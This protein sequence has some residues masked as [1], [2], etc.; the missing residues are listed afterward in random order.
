LVWRLDGFRVLVG[1][2]PENFGE[3]ARV[4]GVLGAGCGGVAGEVLP[5]EVLVGEDA[6]RAAA[7]AA[8]G[9]WLVLSGPVV[10]GSGDR[11]P[12]IYFADGPAGHRARIAGTGKDVWEVVAAVR[13]NDGSA[14]EAA[15][16]LEMP[17]GLVQAAINYYGAHQGEIDQWI[18]G[19]DREATESR[20]AWIAGRTNS[21]KCGE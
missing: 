4:V 10:G 21:G 17:L 20:A 18:E 7:L 1:E 12:L 8:H 19:N 14:A 5:V 15:R 6:D 16:Y 11:G 9:E 2:E 3:M 13:D